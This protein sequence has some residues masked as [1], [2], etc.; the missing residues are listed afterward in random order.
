MPTR[1]PPVLLFLVA[2]AFVGPRCDARGLA[3]PIE[4]VMGEDWAI[5]NYVDLDPGSGVRD[6]RGGNYAYD[7]HNA[8]DF[9]LPNFAAMDRGVGVLA[10][11]AGTVVAVHDGEYDRWSRVNPNPGDRSNL[12]VVDHGG[13][14]LT[15]Y[16][17]LRRNSVAVAVG[18][19]VA[20]G[21]RLGLVGSSGNSSDAHLHFAVYE[22]GRAVETF[23]DPQR[24]W[25]EPLPY[26]GDVAGALDWG[27]TDRFATLGELVERP[28]DAGTFAAG[29]PG[30]L[31]AVWMN[32]HGF[33]AGDL[34]RFEFF[35]PDSTLHR[36]YQW[37]TGEIR[38]GWWNA[39]IGLGDDPFVGVWQVEVS[40]NGEIFATD[41]FRVASVPE[42]A[43]MA[44][45]AAAAFGAGAVRRRRRRTAPAA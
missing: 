27:V 15:E 33:A 45:I 29:V 36:A 32:L 20:K 22:N 9:T 7:G 43:S 40:R 4:G 28:T 39:G 21:Q 23:Q 3:S 30:Q 35:R 5:V 41:S 17:H 1:L 44:L 24:W 16:L 37:V 13:G 12:V 6:W 14:V 18:D 34:L 8:I 38:Y 2:A 42:P 19:R 25:D 11:D 31:A 26:A 10:A